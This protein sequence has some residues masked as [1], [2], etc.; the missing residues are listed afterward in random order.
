MSPLMLDS[1]SQANMLC[2][3]GAWFDG[4][5]ECCVV[6]VTKLGGSNDGIV[7]MTQGP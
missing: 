6:D 5:V 7:E 4:N 3:V 1:V 2:H